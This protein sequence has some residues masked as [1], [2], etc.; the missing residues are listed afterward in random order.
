[1]IQYF[2]ISI[3]IVD[4]GDIMLVEQ[5]GAMTKENADSRLERYIK[6]DTLQRLQGKGLFCGMDYVNIKNLKPIEYYSR[7][8]HSKNVAYSTSSLYRDNKEEYFKVALAGL[9]HDVGTKCFSHANSFKTG[10]ILTQ[11]NDELNVKSILL[12]DEELITYLHEDG[13]NIEDVIDYSKYPILDKPIPALCMDRLDGGILGT[14]LFWAH[15]HT[16]DEIKKLWAMAGYLENTNGMCVDLSSERCKNFTG[17]M[18]LSEDENTAWFEDFF[19]AI[20]VY[21]KILLSKES[22]YMMEVL[23]L[24]LN[25][26][27]DINVID[28]QSMFYLSEQEIIDRILSS[29]YKE[30]WQD[31][32]SFDKVIFAKDIDDG[33]TFISQPKIRQCNPLIID[34]HLNLCE[35]DSI[36]GCFYKELNNIKED[37]YLTKKPITGNLS[38]YTVKTLSRYK[39]R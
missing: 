9:F 25:Y 27:E 29:S 38:K 17:E 26:Y 4:C 6:T 20:N 23:G 33:L 19:K 22:R 37:I 21:S 32:T 10:D 13:I 35:I 14:C 3:L 16:F 8:E 1:M 12:Q 11:E 36:S 7:L 18:V 31:I 34:S 39:K 2:I 24:T 30:I 5:Y 15:T 28:E